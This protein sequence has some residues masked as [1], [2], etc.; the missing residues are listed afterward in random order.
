MEYKELLW[1]KC[2]EKVPAL[3]YDGAKERRRIGGTEQEV[4]T[5]FEKRIASYPQCHWT[6][7]CAAPTVRDYKIKMPVKEGAKPVA[8]QPI[9]FS[10]YDNMRIEYHL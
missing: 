3:D 6:D 8:M 4:K 2:N 9:P 7:G 1:G 5:Y 10:P